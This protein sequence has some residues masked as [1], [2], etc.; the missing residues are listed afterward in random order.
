MATRVNVCHTP[1]NPTDTVIAVRDLGS[2]RDRRVVG[3]GCASA[4]V[5]G[6]M[7]VI[8][9]NPA[10]LAYIA[11]RKCLLFYIGVLLDILDILGILD[12]KV[13]R[14]TVESSVN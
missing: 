12:I 10:T 2:R 8:A 14:L 4:A 13:E 3:S 7:A 6:K 11:G 9:A 5:A 1:S